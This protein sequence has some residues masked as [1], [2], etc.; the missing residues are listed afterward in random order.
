MEVLNT[1]NVHVGE[2]C[3]VVCRGQ[4]WITLENDA[5]VTFTVRGEKHLKV[6]EAAPEPDDAKPPKRAKKAPKHLC[7]AAT[8]VEEEPPVLPSRQTQALAVTA[9]RSMAPWGGQ[10][11]GVDVSQMA[12]ATR[13]KLESNKK[14]YIIRLLVGDAAASVVEVPRYCGYNLVAERAL[15]DLDLT[16]VPNQL[17]FDVPGCQIVGDKVVAPAYFDSISFDHL[18]EILDKVDELGLEGAFKVCRC[19]QKE[20]LAMSAWI[21]DDKKL[22]DKHDLLRDVHGEVLRRDRVKVRMTKA[23]FR[24]RQSLATRKLYRATAQADFDRVED[25]SA[26]T[27]VR[28]GVEHHRCDAVATTPWVGSR[29]LRFTQVQISIFDVTTVV[30]GTTSS[31]ARMQEVQ[32]AYENVESGY[33]E[34]IQ[35]R[36]SADTRGSAASIM[37]PEDGPPELVRSFTHHLQSVDPVAETADD[38]RALLFQLSIK[39]S[40]PNGTAR[41][42][43][44]A[45]DGIHINVLQDSILYAYCIHLNLGVDVL[46]GCFREGET[47]ETGMASI[48]EALAR[49]YGIVAK[50]GLSKQNRRDARAR[51]LQEPFCT[52]AVSCSC[53]WC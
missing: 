5:E 12:R 33:I 30:P 27:G 45:N 20:A 50:S 51:A 31:V 2:I 8:A 36:G 43:F 3:K 52:P 40:E 17:V 28:F 16:Y 11:G 4:C 18:K 1:W 14:P 13:P 42:N 38:L 34:G 47:G 44:G 39:N 19:L 53:L 41:S 25:L 37:F 35:L 29:R 26:K 24:L 23:L 49:H 9:Q 32:E 21:E 48:E 10:F 7:G 46:G 15:G 22:T 6:I